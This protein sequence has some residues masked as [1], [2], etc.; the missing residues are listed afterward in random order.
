[1][2]IEVAQSKD[3]TVLSHTKYAMEI[4]EE[5]SLLSAKPIETP[6]DPNAKL[7]PNQGEPPSD[8]GRYRKLVGRL[9]YLTITC[10]DISFV[11]NVVSQFLNSPHE[12]HWNAVI[13]ILKYVKGAPRKGL[14]YED[15]GHIE[16][17]GA[18]GC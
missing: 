10:L 9:S 18:L 8:T 13:C 4:L 1:M 6:M 14:I 15:K 11:V 12:G 7:L 17:V 5:T 2:E 3:G 16:I